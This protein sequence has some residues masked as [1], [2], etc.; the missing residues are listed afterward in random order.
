MQLLKWTA[1]FPQNGP[2]A[3]SASFL[4]LPSTTIAETLRTNQLRY[5]MTLTKKKKVYLGPNIKICHPEFKNP[6]DRKGTGILQ[7]RNVGARRE[8]T[9]RTRR[10]Y[11]CFRQDFGNCSQSSRLQ[12]Q[13]TY[14]TQTLSREDRRMERPVFSFSFIT[15]GSCFAGYWAGKSFL[16][17]NWYQQC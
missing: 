17:I 7:W 3:F 8:K 13:Y 11:P 15:L 10:P 14:N 16:K 12:R 6:M 9:L 5:L 4:T 1:A 2:G